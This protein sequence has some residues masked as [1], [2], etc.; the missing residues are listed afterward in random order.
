MTRPRSLV[1]AVMSTAWF[2]NPSR[3]RAIFAGVTV[4]FAILSVWPRHYTAEAQLLPQDSGSGL[5]AAL[6]GAGT[7][8]V[9]SLGALIGNKQP[10]ESDL[11]IARSHAV[12]NLIGNRLHLEG[13]EG[14]ETPDKIALRLRR[15]LSIISIRGSILQIT[16]ADGDPAFARALV[17]AAAASIQDRLAAISVTEAAEKRAVATDRLNEA[18]ISLAHAQAA[19]QHFQVEHELAAP[20]EE[21][22]AAVGNLAALEGRLQAKQVELTT[23]RTFAT[24]DNIKVQAAEAE[25]AALRRQVE[26]AKVAV[27]SRDTANLAGIG[28]IN[29]EYFNLYRD[30]REAEI[31]FQVYKR[32]LEEVVV[33]AMSANQNLQLVEPAYVYPERQYN[34]W[35]VGLMITVM[36][37]AGLS[38]LYL[39]R[40]PVKGRLGRAAD[41]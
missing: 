34:L 12:L 1:G 5:S 38:E 26:D 41:V 10:V 27:P 15:Q 32:Y 29:T 8:G 23:L 4:V 35:A 3:R 33:D 31:L 39:L 7:G 40:P 22:G 24:A 19:L 30:E 36:I 11:T 16:A 18:T 9:L 20:T 37:A 25:L 21:L 13:R 14:F 6:Q 2:S 28:L 17:G